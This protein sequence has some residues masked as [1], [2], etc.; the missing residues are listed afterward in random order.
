MQCYCQA[1]GDQLY[2]SRVVIFFFDH[3]GV[4]KADY[5]TFD[6]PLLKNAGGL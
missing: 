6:T 2:Q 1:L 4:S 5:V 3:E